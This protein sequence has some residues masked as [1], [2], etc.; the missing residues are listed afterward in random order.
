MFLCFVLRQLS[1]VN[2]GRKGCRVIILTWC[3]GLAS[4]QR[5]NRNILVSRT[6]CIRVLP[7]TYSQFDNFLTALVWLTALGCRRNDPFWWRTFSQTF[8]YCSF[9]DFTMVNYLLVVMASLKRARNIS[10]QLVFSGGE[11][12]IFTLVA[13]WVMQRTT[14]FQCVPWIYSFVRYMYICLKAVKCLPF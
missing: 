6:A 5:G 3:N 8:T 11:K 2:R 14:L 4:H 12:S 7:T 10:V 13:P 9:R 1:L